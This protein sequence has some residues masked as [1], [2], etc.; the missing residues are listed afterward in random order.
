MIESQYIGKT[1]G[2]WVDGDIFFG[3]NITRNFSFGKDKNKKKDW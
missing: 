2:D 3:F 1:G